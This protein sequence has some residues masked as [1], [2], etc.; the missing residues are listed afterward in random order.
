[1]TFIRE[2]TV[3]DVAHIQRI[4]SEAFNSPLSRWLGKYSEAGKIAQS[5]QSSR[6]IIA[7]DAR[8]YVAC[9]ASGKVT[10][11]IS[12]TL[13]RNFVSTESG[14]WLSRIESR[15]YALEQ[16]LLNIPALYAARKETGERQRKFHALH[17][18]FATKQRE[19]LETV[20]D[21][22][23][24]ELLCVDPATHGSGVG[25][26]LLQVALNLAKQKNLPCYLESS[27]MGFNFYLNRGFKDMKQGTEI[28]DGDTYIDTLASVIWYA[29]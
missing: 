9:D 13:N 28:K 21:Y 7:G 10:G 27:A 20:R 25:G 17:E 18:T 24:V 14:T 8:R 22:V 19:L 2:A 23:Y 16:A 3:A 5:I 4:K 26:Q 12:F 15:L 6:D 1:M 29:P 11:V